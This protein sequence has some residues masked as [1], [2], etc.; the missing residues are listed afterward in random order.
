MIVCPPEVKDE[1]K[2]IAIQLIQD[3][4]FLEINDSKTETSHFRRDDKGIL[5]LINTPPLR[6]LGFEFNGQNIY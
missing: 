1:L 6:Y 4:F 2:N 5:R 3:N